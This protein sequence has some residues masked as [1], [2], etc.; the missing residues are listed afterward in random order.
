MRVRVLDKAFI[1]QE[2]D[3]LGLKDLTQ[4]KRGHP[5]ERYSTGK[6]VG[7]PSFQGLI[8]VNTWK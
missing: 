3:G 6:G 4:V 7:L 8:L 5:N 2:G 1:R